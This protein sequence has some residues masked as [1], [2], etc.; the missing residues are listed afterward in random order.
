MGSTTL[1]L[2][3][4]SIS[5]IAL[6]ITGNFGE[7]FYLLAG[8]LLID[9]VLNYQNELA[10]IQKT[11]YIF[12]STASAFYI[13]NASNSNINMAKGI[14][15]ILAVNEL[16]R[17]YQE[18]K[19]FLD[20]YQ[21]NHPNVSPEVST[22]VTDTMDAAVQKILLAMQSQN[23]SVPGAASVLPNPTLIQSTFKEGANGE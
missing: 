21:K 16:G 20:L 10:F 22:N 9:F 2:G 23:I 13:Q 15:I 6:W 19:N 11:G 5:A 1:K 12:L 3:G 18:I 8:L 14:V 17:V 7:A 4:L